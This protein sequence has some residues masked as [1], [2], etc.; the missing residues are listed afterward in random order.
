MVAVFPAELD[1]DSSAAAESWDA[2]DMA[3]SA[4]VSEV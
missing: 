3:D 4:G 1:I 2:I